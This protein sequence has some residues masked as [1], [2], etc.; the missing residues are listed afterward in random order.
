M[1]F[2][3]KNYDVILVK[4]ERIL[5]YKDMFSTGTPFTSDVLLLDASSVGSQLWIASL[6][7]LPACGRSY[8]CFGC[9]G[10]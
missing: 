8:G 2:R 6:V 4:L 10:R 3:S 1:L 7:R 5:V 9:F